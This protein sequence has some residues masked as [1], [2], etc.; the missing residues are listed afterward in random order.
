MAGSKKTGVRDRIL[1]R[2]A[3]L[4]YR[5]GFSG[6]GV[7][8]IIKEAETVPASFYNHFPSKSSLGIAYVEARGQVLL[9]NLQ[10][11][12][13][14]ENSVIKLL[15]AWV[16]FKKSQIDRREFLGC[17]VAGFAYQAGELPAEHQ[18]AARS[19]AVTWAV[20]LKEFFD[21]A[22]E[23]GELKQK[24]DTQKMAREVLLV[25]EGS[26]AMWKMTLDDAYLDD[27]QEA[28]LMI[29]ERYHKKKNAIP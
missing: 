14:R 5:G 19:I 6:V 8:E 7:R 1:G 22:V 24:T 17:P 15:H 20:H 23:T 29:Y 13:K 18:K 4:F 28:F 2:A 10:T 3:D 26:L 16:A 21:R 9:R 12:I 27:M 25:Y 11:I